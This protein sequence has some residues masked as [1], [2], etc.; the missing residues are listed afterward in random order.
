L[1]NASTSFSSVTHG[2]RWDG[3]RG[4]HAGLNADCHW[5]IHSSAGGTRIPK[6]VDDLDAHH[7][8]VCIG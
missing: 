8:E 5:F 1:L 4:S 2:V 6:P 3:G 7:P